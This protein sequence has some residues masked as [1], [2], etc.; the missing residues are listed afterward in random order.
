MQRASRLLNRLLLALIPLLGFPGLA[1]GQPNSPVCPVINPLSHIS[2]IR[3]LSPAIA[4]C[5]YPVRIRGVVT[6][7]SGWR[8]AFFLQDSTGAISIERGESTS[9]QSGDEIVVSGF[10][11]PGKFIPLIVSKKI[12]VIDKTQ[13]PKPKV[14][15]YS[16]LISGDFDSEWV[17]IEGIVHSATIGEGWGRSVLFLNVNVDGNPLI[18]R[19]YDFPQT[20]VDDLV[21]ATVRIRGACGS[22]FNDKRQLLGVRLFTPDLD[23]IK[24]ESPAVKSSDDLPELHASKIFQFNTHKLLA[25]RIKVHGTVL[26]QDENTLYVQAE[27]Q[28]VIVKGAQT[29]QFDSG[30]A[31]EAIGFV[32]PGQYPVAL[33]EARVR[34]IG[35]GSPPKPVLVTPKDFVQDNE[36]FLFAPYAGRW[37]RT[38]AK[39]VDKI[40]RG[41]TEVWT[42]KEDNQVFQLKLNDPHRVE[43]FS[44][45]RVGSLLRIEGLCTTDYD[46][47]KQPTS[48]SILITSRGNITVLKAAPSD[49]LIYFLL[50]AALGAILVA[51]VWSLTHARRLLMQIKQNLV[52]RIDNPRVHFRR[53]PKLCAIIGMTVPLIVLIGGWGLH[54]NIL[55]TFIQGQPAM[56]P[57]TALGFLCAG[58]A[59][60]LA[61]TRSGSRR[62]ISAACSLVTV[63]IGAL[64]LFEYACPVNLGI[65]AIISRGI[66]S[67]ASTSTRM[68]PT[69]AVCLILVGFAVALV[70]RKGWASLSQFLACTAVAVCLFNILGYLYQVHDASV[71]GIP[72]GMAIHSIIT[73][74]ILIAGILTMECDRG[75]M[76]I[77]MANAPGGMMARWLI[78]ISIVLPALLGWLRWYAQFR[79]GA[80]DTVVG[81]SIFASSNIIITVVLL[82]VGANLLNRADISREHMRFI[83][84]HDVLT[85]LLNRKGIMEVLE[86]E[87][88]HC[89]RNGAPLSVLLAD[90]DHFKSINDT[91][92][93][94]AGD[95]V[96]REISARLRNSVREDDYVG[97]LG[98]E[99]FLLVLPGCDLD[100]AVTRAEQLR[101]QIAEGPMHAGDRFCSVTLSLGAAAVTDT[102][103][104]D[105]SEMLIHQADEAL[106][107][108]KQGGRNQ[109]RANVSLY[110]AA[111]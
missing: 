17:Q 70:R 64:S 24:I 93:H 63:L 62:R 56:V 68:A 36:G 84:S 72:M 88:S 79:L 71:F 49:H 101:R 87:M 18:V 27:D 99:E 61:S 14:L 47:E 98:G 44:W 35:S 102:L 105:S 92:G 97:R 107:G 86:R 1:L 4:S 31:V 16:E 74:L 78:P 106:Y 20:G 39:L 85:S 96:L 81:L 52:V 25:H 3:Q 57:N 29:G 2:Q 38:D 5:G 104:A 100:A 109:V 33:S 82:W 75:I 15:N 10:T 66:G 11:G 95:D 58:M 23:S 65:D 50:L 108:A 80:F 6:V 53:L 19:V 73:F 110:S 32:V 30:A 76:E 34:K 8:G 22:I 48:I 7:L 69:T 42:L 46:S 40:R 41:Q 77:I 21:D 60:A 54:I 43:K 37:I 90:V 55:R 45:I 28:A 12:D 26:D 111:I 9:V 67:D 94:Q 103:H 13:L 51:I 89:K 83:A 91:L 59:L